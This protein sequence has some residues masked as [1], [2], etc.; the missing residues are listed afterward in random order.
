MQLN[1]F[2][3]LCALTILFATQAVAQS[4]EV[5]RSSEKFERF[6][7][8]VEERYMED[9][10]LEEA[11]ENAI[12]AVLEELD[13]HS[14]YFSA[15]ELKKANE[16]LV[17]NF[18][19]VGIQFNI[20]KDTIFVLATIPG[21]PSEKV[22]L[23]AGDKIIKVDEEVVAGI[24]M[25]NKG[26]QD[27]LRGKKGT[28]VDVAVKRRGSKELLD[29]TITRDKIPLYALD[30]GYMADPE[31]GYIK[32][33][34][35][36]AT[37]VDE[38]KE[39]LSELKSQGMENLIL[40]LRGNGGGYLNAATELANEF[41]DGRKLIVYTEGRAYPRQEAYSDNAGGWTDGKLIVLINEGSASASEIVSGAVQDWDRALVI[42]RRSFGKGLVQRPF[43]LTDGSAVR[44][45]VQKY[46]TPSGRSIQRPYDEG[47]EAYRDEFTRRLEAG[48]LMSD[49]EIEFPDS[50]KFFTKNRKRIVYGG[51]GITPDIFIA[52]DTSFSTD[53]YGD[54]LR[55]GILNEFSL[56]YAD[57]NREEFSKAFPD[58]QAFA[59][60]F[61]MD[62]PSWDEFFA[63]AE[64]KEVEINEEELALSKDRIDLI[65][66][67]MI[68][69]NIYDTEAYYVVY[70]QED[71]TYLRALAAMK[72]KTFKQMKIASK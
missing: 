51:G 7:D 59:Y 42:G 39:A 55:K 31:T 71:E 34:R 32:L 1:R 13:P 53:Y 47:V 23:L 20:L 36:S 40:D 33:N 44:L 41:L 25:T 43:P 8:L 21:G 69:R 65:L 17:G 12:R 38:F 37:T 70:N 3:A 11:V 4:G 26:V 15:E 61:K 66:R 19:G 60:G 2:L 45:T 22:G 72:D 16:P 58:A 30:A 63:F 49:D 28:K 50:L 57:K 62:G 18:E 14:T 29:F 46:F 5:I 27:R 24:D 10:E 56:T 52:L 6:L 64:S 48:E 35:F 9:V 67:S 68:A 54:V